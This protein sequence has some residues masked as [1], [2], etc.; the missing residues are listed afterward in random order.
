M[1]CS[2]PGLSVPHHLLKFA[3]VRVHCIGDVIQPSHLL[4]PCSPSALNLSQHQGLSQWVSCSHQM[5]KILEFQ[6]QHQ[7]FQWVFRVDFPEDGLTWSPCYPMDSQEPSL[8]PL[9]KSINF[10][11][12]R[13]LYDP[14]L[15]TVRDHW[16]DHSLDYMD[17]CWQSN[18]SAFQHTVWV[19]HSF[20]AKKQMSS[21]FMAA[22]IICSDFRTQEEELYHYFHIFP[23]YLPWSNGKCMFN[24]TKMQT[25]FQSCSTI[26]PS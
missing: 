1:D 9:F 22:V 23:L 25:I 19:C 7:S 26:L 24:F 12:L 16:E 11:M 13:L 10:W 20:P 14:A 6:L 2:T 5:T 17:L 21:N 3:Q 4:M 15:T 18:V 8:A